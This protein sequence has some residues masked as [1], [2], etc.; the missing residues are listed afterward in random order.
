[1]TRASTDRENTMDKYEIAERIANSQRV[2]KAALDSLEV[3]EG[4]LRRLQNAVA[5]NSASRSVT[6]IAEARSALDTAMF[7]VLAANNK[8]LAA[9]G[10]VV[11]EG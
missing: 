11:V 7:A 10:T 1:M 5:L 3:S 6:A 8:L 4:N 9:A 2:V